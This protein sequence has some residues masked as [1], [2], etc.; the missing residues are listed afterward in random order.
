M[1]ITLNQDE[2]E[3][4]VRHFVTSQITVAEGQ[5]I[6]VDFTAGRGDK[7]MSASLTIAPAMPRVKPAALRTTRPAPVEETAEVEAEEESDIQDAEDDGFVAEVEGAEDSEQEDP[8]EAGDDDSAEEE[9][10]D[11]PAPKRGSIFKK[12]KKVAEDA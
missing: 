8:E 7:G 9:G 3:D 5:K 10:E 1:Q 4:A 12:K 11:G 6:A 2:L